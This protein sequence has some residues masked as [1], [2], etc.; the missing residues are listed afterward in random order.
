MSARVIFVYFACQMACA[1]LLRAQLQEKENGDAIR[2]TVSKNQDGSSTT[3]EFDNANRKAIATTKSAAG[4]AVSKIRYDLD[5]AGRFAAGEV[6][7]PDGKLRF[8]TQYKY[9]G[10]GHLTQETQLSKEDAVQNKIVYSYDSAGKQT[11]Y[12]V[13]DGA[14]RMLG[15]TTPVAS[16]TAQPKKGK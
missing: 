16:K 8:K 9:D 14:G 7:G 6:F 2:V 15:Q 5:D 11:G 10:S 1:P 4:K 13:Y 12:A 3:Y